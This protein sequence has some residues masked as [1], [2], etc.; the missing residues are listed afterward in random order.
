MPESTLID[1]R[2]KQVIFTRQDSGD[3]EIQVQREKC[4]RVEGETFVKH[5]RV[6]DLDGASHLLDAVDLGEFGSVTLADLL[7]VFRELAELWDAG[8]RTRQL[9][10]CTP[11]EKLYS[12]ICCRESLD[13]SQNW[14]PS[15]TLSFSLPDIQSHEVVVSERTWTVPI[16]AAAIRAMCDHWAGD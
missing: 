3:F 2:T 8:G 6:I 14:A 16:L 10:I 1:Y 9:I 13:A 7:S 11:A 4:V 15:R 12:V 5:D